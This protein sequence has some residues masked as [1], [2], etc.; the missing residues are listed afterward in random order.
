VRTGDISNRITDPEASRDLACKYLA[1]LLV[2]YAGIR[3]QAEAVSQ[4]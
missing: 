4:E 3:N 1:D 2:A